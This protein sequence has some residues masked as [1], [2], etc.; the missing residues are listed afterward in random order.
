MQTQTCSHKVS[1]FQ[2]TCHDY[3]VIHVDLSKLTVQ[4]LMYISVFL[5]LPNSYEALSVQTSEALANVQTE[6]PRQR[7]NLRVEPR[8][9]RC[10]RLL[11]ANTR[12]TMQQLDILKYRGGRVKIMDQIS[13]RWHKVA[14]HLGFDSHEISNIK[15][16]SLLN[17]ED[18]CMTMFIKW[19]EG[20]K[21]RPTWKTLVQA[22]TD[23]GFQELAVEIQEM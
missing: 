22:L 2:S 3:T 6:S 9:K 15:Q 16:S 7:E 10:W 8:P 14:I 5:D 4:L 1:G 12:P 19:L 20:G 23:A 18:A 17:P 21:K 11:R 13:H